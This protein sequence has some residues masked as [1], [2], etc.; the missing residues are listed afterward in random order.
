MSGTVT[1]FWRMVWEHR[2][3]CIMMLCQCEEGGKVSGVGIGVGR[4]GEGVR[5]RGEGGGEEM[6]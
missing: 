1:D 6:G 3:S 2:C 5:R 4:R